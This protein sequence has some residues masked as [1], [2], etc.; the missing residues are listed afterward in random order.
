MALRKRV[1]LDE[2]ANPVRY[3]TITDGNYPRFSLLFQPRDITLMRLKEAPFALRSGIGTGEPSRFWNRPGCHADPCRQKLIGRICT[4]RLGV[5]L[6][7]RR[8]ECRAG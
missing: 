5:S 6:G 3:Q 2:S 8:R 7:D 1:T 4:V